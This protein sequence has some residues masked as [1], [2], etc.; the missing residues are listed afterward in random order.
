MR[1]FEAS[2]RALADADRNVLELAPAD[3]SKPVGRPHVEPAQL[4]EELIQLADG[5][6]VDLHQG[7]A[8][9]QSRLRS[10]ST[11]LDRDHQ[12]SAFL[13]KL[14]A[15]RLAKPNRLGAKTKV[16][17]ADPAMRLQIL[18][19]CGG[20]LDGNGAGDAAA[21]VPAVDPDHPAVAVEE[22][23]AGKAGQQFGG[24][25]NQ[26]LGLTPAPGA[27]RAREPADGSKS[28]LQLAGATD[29]EHEMAD[30]DLGR[31]GTSQRPG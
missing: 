31:S 10:R 29:G 28:D 21:E 4:S 17:A 18:R 8:L 3:H 27:K 26:S 24:G 11:G 9:H 25:L 6:A 16:G 22:R 7:V 2:G 15:Q 13:T 30:P 12:Q 5:I 1:A 23:A 20:G 14:A 19:H